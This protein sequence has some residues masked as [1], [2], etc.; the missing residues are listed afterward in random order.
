MIKRE[1]RMIQIEQ[2]KGNKGRNKDL[3][4]MFKIE[5]RKH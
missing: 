5:V 3:K 4:R 2:L 1:E